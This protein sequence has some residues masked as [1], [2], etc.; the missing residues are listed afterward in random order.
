MTQAEIGSS[1]RHKAE[2]PPGYLMAPFGWAAKPLAGMLKAEPS[3]CS[4]LFTLSRQHMHLIAL[5]LAHWHGALDAQF[6]RLVMAGLPATVLDHVLGR[7]PPGLKRALGHLPVG[8]LPRHSYL[9]LIELLEDPAAAKLIYHAHCLSEEYLSGLHATPSSLRWFVGSTGEGA[10][11]SGLS[12]GLRLLAAR[13]AAANFETL[14]A[15]LSATRQPAQFAARLAR[16]IEQLPLPPIMPPQDVGGA[17]RI[18]RAVDIRRLAKRWK[19][20]LADGYLDTVNDGRAA[21]Y[22]WPHAQAPAACVVTRHGRLAWTLFDAKGRRD[23][24]AGSWLRAGSGGRDQPAVS[25][26]AAAGDDGTGGAV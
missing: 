21:V 11:A 8:V 4:A 10:T 6:A 2:R 24:R 18:D 13:G 25:A 23:R 16:L 22:F 3:L 9:H 14:V 12:D 5:S 17:R 7:R 26:V 1:D 19:N 20:C 15:N